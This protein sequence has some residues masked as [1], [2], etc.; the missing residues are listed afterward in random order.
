MHSRRQ[1]F[2]HRKIVTQS[3]RRRLQVACREL[4]SAARWPRQGNKSPDIADKQRIAGVEIEVAC[5]AKPG[6]T[7]IVHQDVGVTGHLG[8]ANSVTQVTE[9]DGMA[10]RQIFGSTSG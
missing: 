7:R 10:L 3:V 8:N 2:H 6:D 9:Q 1:F 5:R 4:P